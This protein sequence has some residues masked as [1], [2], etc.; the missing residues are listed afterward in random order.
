MIFDYITLKIIWFILIAILLAGFAIM[1]G[2][3]MGVSALLPMV[4]KKDDERRVL[5]NTIGPMWEGNQVWLILAAGAIFAAWPIAYATAFSG[6]YYALFLVLATLII[7]P[8]GFDY[9]SKINSLKW[10][11]AWDVCLFLSGVV[12]ALVFGVGVGNLFLGVPF[13]FDI[14]AMPFYTGTFFGLLNPFALLIGLVSLGLLCT[15]GALFIQAK[16]EGVLQARAKIMSRLF[17][18]LFIASFI[19]AGFWVHKVLIGYQITF[20]PDLNT[21][22]SVQAKTVERLAGAWSG[23]YQQWPYFWAV[24]FLTICFVL[25]S[26]MLSTFNYV[27]TAVLVHSCAIL[28]CVATAATA[29]FPF[30]MPSSRFPS[31]SLTVWDVASSHMTLQWMFWAVVILLPIVLLYTTWVVRVFRGP[32]REE[33]V[34]ANPDS[35]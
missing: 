15:Q 34:A 10:R 19:L 9:R 22:M 35:Y 8:P 33:T 14:T 12:P 6:M 23:N 18:L 1:G 25:C 2:S 17:G 26:M 5:I 27:K 32:L 29:L 28:G 30:V 3:D 11:K 4:G 31:H 21:A 24:P 16:T 7:R 13:Y 20:I